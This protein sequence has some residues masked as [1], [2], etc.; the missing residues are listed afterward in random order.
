MR[1]RHL[2]VLA[3]ALV[4]GC[5]TTPA[6]PPTPPGPPPPKPLSPEAAAFFARAEAPDAR[7]AMVVNLDALDALGLLGKGHVLRQM[8]GAA[9][10]VLPQLVPMPQENEGALLARGAVAASVLRQWAEWPSAQR[11]GV[12]LLGG[13][14]LQGSDEELARNVVLAL[15]VEEGSPDNAKLLV[16][17]AALGRSVAE[18]LSR[19]GADVRLALVGSDLCLQGVELKQPVCLRPRRGLML[20]GTPAALASLDVAMSVAPETAAAP[21]A[22]AAAPAPVP[23]LVGMRVDLGREGRASLALTGRDAVNLVV[24]VEGTRPHA[25]SSI[26]NLVKKFLRDFDERETLKR[27]RISTALT[28]VKG[29]LAQDTTAPADLKAA[30]NALTVQEVVDAHGYWA[31]LRQSL[32]AQPGPDGYTLSLTVPAGMVKD[33]S[34]QLGNGGALLVSALGASAAVAIPNFIKYQSRAKQAEVKANLKMA[35]TAQRAFAAENDRWGRT[36]EEIGFEPEKGRRYTYCMGSECLPCDRAGCGP[37]PEPSPCAGITRVGKKLS[38]GFT[39]CAYGN[40]DD[41]PDLD[42]WVIDRDGVPQQLNA[43]LP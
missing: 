7:G 38:D 28:Q 36:F 32:Q 8:A 39:L 19:E 18:E 35:Y 31:Q 10:T 24:R 29:A 16:G 22:S 6:T 3:A 14:G 17:L 33:F 20:L 30:A 4:A 15:A 9:T 26:D 41:D 12:L 13:R 43:D 27:E 21:A 5:A 23:L 42:V 1:L 2:V 37:A 34:E 25:V 11:F 40:V